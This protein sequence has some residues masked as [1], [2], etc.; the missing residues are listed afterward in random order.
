MRQSITRF[1]MS[2]AAPCDA[3]ERPEH[4]GLVLRHFHHLAPPSL[5]AAIEE[6]DA[7]KLREFMTRLKAVIREYPRGVTEEECT[8]QR[9][10]GFDLQVLCAFFHSFLDREYRL[11][12][13]P[14]LPFPQRKG[15]ASGSTF[16]GAPLFFF[17]F[18][19][20]LCFCR[21]RGGS[22]FAATSALI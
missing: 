12:P 16:L 15:T 1:I 21:L 9:A 18:S 8:R 4:S 17:S 14:G 6:E 11:S 10:L 7:A 13:D 20:S 5:R 2:D 22:K 3:I 19:F